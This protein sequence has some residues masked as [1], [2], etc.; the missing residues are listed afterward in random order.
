[1]ELVLKEPQDT[2]SKTQL[3]IMFAAEIIHG[4]KRH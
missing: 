2:Y 4:S 3:E 1:M